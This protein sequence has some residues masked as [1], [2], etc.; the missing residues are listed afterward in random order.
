MLAYCVVQGK[1][2]MNGLDRIVNLSIIA[3]YPEN[4]MEARQYY[5][6]V[7]DHY[8]LDEQEDVIRLIAKSKHL[9]DL[10][11]EEWYDDDEVELTEED[12]E[13]MSG[14]DIYELTHPMT[15]EEIINW[16]IKCIDKSKA[17]LKNSSPLK[18]PRMARERRWVCKQRKVVSHRLRIV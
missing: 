1:M 8:P 2:M 12:Y 4:A 6:E 10:F 9:K 5:K 11:P 7:I 3:M 14:N 15:D 17:C 18:K 13:C 16:I